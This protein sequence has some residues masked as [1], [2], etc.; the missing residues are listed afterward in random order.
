MGRAA[1]LRADRRAGLAP[2]PER[3]RPS[4]SLRDLLFDPEP[5]NADM[6]GFVL[7]EEDDES[8]PLTHGIRGYH[9]GGCR[10]DICTE[11]QAAYMRD[12]RQRK[13]SALV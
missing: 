8:I 6:D 7:D 9:F 13:R 12:Y 4:E 2:K 5:A 10:C 11:A 3:Y 1:R